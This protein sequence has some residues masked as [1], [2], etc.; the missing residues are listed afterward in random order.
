M[1]IYICVRI[2]CLDVCMCAGSSWLVLCPDTH[3]LPDRAGHMAIWWEIQI[4]PIGFDLFD[5]VSLTRRV[6]V[7][8]IASRHCSCLFFFVCS[9]ACHLLLC[10]TDEIKYFFFSSF[11]TP[12][13]W[14]ALSSA[15]EIYGLNLVKSSIYNIDQH[16]E[17]RK[18]CWHFSLLSA[19]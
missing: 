13:H 2:P 18:L 8:H 5:L 7:L 10:L 15:V 4:Q 9:S 12:F 19:S 16:K 3:M 1:L 6:C 17:L 14:N 11:T